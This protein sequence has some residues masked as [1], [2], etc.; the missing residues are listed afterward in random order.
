MA[1]K[2]WDP[3]YSAEKQNNSPETNTCTCISFNMHFLALGF[4]VGTF[5]TDKTIYHAL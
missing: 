5:S 2:T 4:V 3:D 1:T